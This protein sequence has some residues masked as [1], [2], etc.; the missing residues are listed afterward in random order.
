MAS[1]FIIYGLVDPRDGQLRYVGKSCSGLTRPKV[2]TEPRQLR[3]HTHQA[4]WLRSMGQKPI[5]VVIHELPD[6]EILNDAERYWIA[7]FRAM[8]CSL[9]NATDGGDGLSHGFKHSL[10]T[11]VRMSLSKM[12]NKNSPGWPKGK[13]RVTPRPPPT[14]DTRAKMAASARARWARE[15]QGG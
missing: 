7:Y 3:A 1:K 6:V 12:G 5:V 10:E 2:H 11:R 14:L 4:S 15:V 9:T 8:G 13:P